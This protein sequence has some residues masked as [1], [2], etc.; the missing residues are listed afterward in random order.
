MYF[1]TEF[2]LSV[3]GVLDEPYSQL[4]PLSGVAIQARQSTRLE[5]C[6]SYAAWRAGMATQ[7]S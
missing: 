3:T 5:P 4:S 1:G 7:L 6:P 2:F